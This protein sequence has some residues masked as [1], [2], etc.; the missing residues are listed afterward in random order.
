[1]SK[2]FLTQ[3]IEGFEGVNFYF[4]PSSSHHYGNLSDILEPF[5]LSRVRLGSSTVDDP[6][7]GN[8]MFAITDFQV[9]EVVALYTGNNQGSALLSIA[10]KWTFI[11]VIFISNS[12]VISQ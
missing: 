7:A 4:D 6:K 10:L 5:E 11:R 1:M 8:G 12:N 2:F 3:K 9:G